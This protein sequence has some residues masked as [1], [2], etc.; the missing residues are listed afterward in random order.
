[1]N[2]FILAGWLIVGVANMFSQRI[3]KIDYFMC[4]SILILKLIQS[5]I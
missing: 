1:M 4:W 5:V 3:T 2:E